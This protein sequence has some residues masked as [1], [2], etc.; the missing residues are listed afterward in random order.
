MKFLHRLTT[1]LGA[2]FLAASSGTAFAAPTNVALGKTVT[3]TS[4]YNSGSETF[5]YSQVVDGRTTDTGAGFNW[6]FWISA[7]GA[8]VGQWVQVD[9]GQL[10]SIS[11][12]VLFD[13]HNRGYY[14]RGTNAYHVGVSSDGNSFTTLGSGNFTDAEWRN[15]TADTLNA[16]SGTNARYVRFY[17]DSAY[18][19]SVGLAEL[20]VWGEAPVAVPEPL[21]LSLVAAGLATLALR[22]KFRT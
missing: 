5:P 19:A 22:R 1:A 14:D 11:S 21:S 17:A 3:G 6:S 2:L 20:Q 10:Y 7:G 13:T 8:I 15:Q 18:G 9:L 4:Y 12:V 16:A